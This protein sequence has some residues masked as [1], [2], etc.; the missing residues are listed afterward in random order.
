[1]SIDKPSRRLLLQAAL[2][3]LACS[4]PAQERPPVFRTRRYQFTEI[5][6]VVPMPSLRLT[7]LDGKP[8]FVR[9]VAGQVTL[10]YLWAT[11]CPICRIELPLL[12][13]QMPALKRNGVA[14]STICTDGP[15]P[16][17]VRAYLARLGVAQLPVFWDRDG[18]RLAAP[19]ADGGESP[20]T[21]ASGLPIT[22]LVDPRGGVRGYLL[23]QADW[24]SPEAA[25]ILGYFARA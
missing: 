21:L 20:F 13:S 25:A 16:Q 3:V 14:L 10:V 6:P 12:E 5:E 18:K 1:M 8:A 15:D 7:R 19:G 24:M 9:P 23:G 11:W 2:G 4:A 17:S 22:Y